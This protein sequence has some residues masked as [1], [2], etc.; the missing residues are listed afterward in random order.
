MG[1]F[2]ERTKS[3]NHFLM[4][5]LKHHSWVRSVALYTEIMSRASRA[6]TLKMPVKKQ[7]SR[8]NTSEGEVHNFLSDCQFKL[9]SGIRIPF[10]QEFLTNSMLRVIRWFFT[11]YDPICILLDLTDVKSFDVDEMNK[12]KKEILI[13]I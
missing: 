9:K 6:S 10:R 3:L 5:I 11:Y 7:A 2:C 4:I 13:Q 8:V 12:L 1:L